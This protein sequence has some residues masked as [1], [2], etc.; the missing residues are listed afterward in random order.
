MSM[1]GSS[2]ARTALGYTSGAGAQS[3]L[4]RLGLTPQVSSRLGRLVDKIVPADFHI[5]AGERN[6]L[7]A[8]GASDTMTARALGNLLD[9]TD[10]VAFMEDL[11][12]KL[13]Q[14]GLDLVEP[15]EPHGGEPTYKLRR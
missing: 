11:V 10:A 14:F 8:L 6:A 9:L 12:R 4:V 1:S 15:G 3:A 13:E 2:T 5:D 7:N